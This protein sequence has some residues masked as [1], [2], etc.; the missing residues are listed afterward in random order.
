[1]KDKIRIEMLY[2]NDKIGYS[3]VVEK[4][5]ESWR[6]AKV[7]W[8]IIEEKENEGKKARAKNVIDKE[9]ENNV[10]NKRYSIP[11]IW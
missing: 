4:K 11:T 7:L 3:K 8:G 10:R 9:S 1:M 2:S 6:R 5:S